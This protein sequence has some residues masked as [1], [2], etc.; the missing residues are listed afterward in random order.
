MILATQFN[1]YEK[2]EYLLPRAVAEILMPVVQV[3]C[4]PTWLLFSE[5][6]SSTQMVC[7]ILWF[8]YIQLINLY[9][10]E[11]WKYVADR[12]LIWCG[13]N[14]VDLLQVPPSYYS[15]ILQQ[16]PHWAF[17]HFRKA[18]RGCHRTNQGTHQTR[19]CYRFSGRV[20][21]HISYHS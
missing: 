20:V 10:G 19:I 18:R 17:R 11:T 1:D 3:T 2:G 5:L 9:L 21:S 14:S 15:S 4:L 13:I 7:I 16:G 6:A 12:D 8:T